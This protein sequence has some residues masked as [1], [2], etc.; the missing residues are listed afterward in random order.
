MSY[1]NGTRLARMSRID[2][3]IDLLESLCT[4]FDIHIGEYGKVRI[5][6][7]TGRRMT[8]ALRATISQCFHQLVAASDAREIAAHAIARASR[9]TFEA[10]TGIDLDGLPPLVVA[11]QEP[12]RTRRGRRARAA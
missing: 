11:E 4:D 9:F 7:R 5:M 6:S 8:P 10:P 2:D 3:A 12:A 1:E